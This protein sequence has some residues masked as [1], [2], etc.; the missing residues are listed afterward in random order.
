MPASG[1]IQLRCCYDA[2]ACS[3][4]GIAVCGSLQT[5]TSLSSM[6]VAAGKAGAMSDFYGYS[7]AVPVCFSFGTMTTLC[8]ITDCCCDVY[9]PVTMT[10]RVSPN[11]MTVCFYGDSN[12]DKLVFA[13]WYT[14]ENGGG[15]VYKGTG[16]IGGFS[17][18]LIDYNDT[19]CVRMQ[20]E[21]VG[22]FAVLSDMFTCLCNPP[23]VFTTGSGTAVRCTPYSCTIGFGFI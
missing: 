15:W 17:Q 18:T 2:V 7:A 20:L 19:L 3:S 10:G 5:P 13:C 1:C 11:V 14:S 6:S 9:L 4:I 8:S 21:D 22:G 12:L 23:A 16:A